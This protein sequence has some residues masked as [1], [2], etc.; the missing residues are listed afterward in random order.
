MVSL[1]GLEAFE[2]TARTGG[3]AAA[4]A[5]LGVSPAAVGQ[6]VRSLEAQ[7][8][9]PLFIRVGRGLTPTEGAMETLPRLSAAFEGL[10]TVAKQLAGESTRARLVV[11]APP[12]VAAAWLTPSLADFI[13]QRGPVDIEVRGETDPVEFERD[14][15]DLRLSYGRFHYRTRETEAVATDAIFPV[16]AVG[17]DDGV[18][19]TADRLSQAPLIHTDW[20]AS[21]AT[22][23]GWRAWFET[24]GDKMPAGVGRGIQVDS[25]IAAINAAFAGLGVALCQGLL[26]TAPISDG[27]L[28]RVGTDAMNLSQPYCLTVPERAVGRPAV[29]ALRVW[30]IEML[31]ASAAPVG[32]R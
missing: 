25:S 14:R 5:E 3:F 10:E 19:P 27:R 1:K 23:P 30:L 26:A 7:M 6:L 13:G 31:R 28:R 24:F 8:G 18:S 22:F 21:S 9:Q 4:A 2:A 29:E 17:A 32:A 16:C 12:S 20:G 11:S 15:I